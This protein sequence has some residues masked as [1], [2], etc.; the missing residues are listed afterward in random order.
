MNEGRASLLTLALLDEQAQADG[1]RGDIR[2]EDI[3]PV[4]GRCVFT[5]HTPVPAGH[6][7]SSMEL[8]NQVLGRREVYHMQEVFCCEGILNMTFL[9]LNLS[10][11]IN[12]VAMSH[13]KVSQKMFSH[14]VI[15]AITNGVHATTW[16]AQPFQTLFDRYVTRL[17]A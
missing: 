2:H 4:R 17:A 16:T 1:R 13:G 12:G 10:H 6:D 14:Y 9:A 8:V 15:D 7:K 3:D 5:T 11:Y